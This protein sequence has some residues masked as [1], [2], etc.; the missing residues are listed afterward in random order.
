[1]EHTCCPDFVNTVSLCISHE[2][3]EIRLP[4]HFQ[5]GV[6]LSALRQM[7][8]CKIGIRAEP[9]LLELA[10]RSHCPT[11]GLCSLYVANSKQH[12][13]LLEVLFLSTCQTNVPAQVVASGNARSC[14]GCHFSRPA[15]LR[16]RRCP[17][18]NSH[19][20]PS[21][22]EPPSSTRSTS[23]GYIS[24]GRRSKEVYNRMQSRVSHLNEKIAVL[25]ARRDDWKK[26]QVGESQ[27]RSHLDTSAD[28]VARV[29]REVE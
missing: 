15:G 13:T 1:A 6:G 25:V 11:I 2:K 21:S 4:S 26:A 17:V 28:E 19:A 23:P 18:V 24:S 29:G 27:S 3:S 5:A 10:M 16:S 8:H 9:R 12:L 20:M 7:P 14:C 22:G